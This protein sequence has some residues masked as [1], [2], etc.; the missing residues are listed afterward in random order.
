M[1]VRHKDLVVEGVQFH[2]ESV[3]TPDGPALMANF[4]KLTAGE[5][6]S[7]RAFAGVA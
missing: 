5:R 7:E 2:P 4:L 1:G 3:L 6:R